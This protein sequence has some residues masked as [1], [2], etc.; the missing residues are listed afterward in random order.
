MSESTPK[1]VGENASSKRSKVPS[2]CLYLGREG[3]AHTYFLQPN[4]AHRCQATTP[5]SAM[6]LAHQQSYCFGACESCERYIAPLVPGRRARPKV[7]GTPAVGAVAEAVHSARNPKTFVDAPQDGAGPDEA[8]LET[9][10]SRGVSGAQNPNDAIAED[11]TRSWWQRFSFEEWT[12]LTVSAAMLG[13]IGYFM[14][15]AEPEGSRASNDLPPLIAGTATANALAVAEGRDKDDTPTKTPRPTRSSS[16]S[17]KADDPAK[18]DEPEATAIPTTRPLTPPAGGLIAALSPSERGVG[19]FREGIELPQYG[20]RNLEVGYFDGNHYLGGMLFSLNKIPDEA[21]VSYV[22]LELAGLSDFDSLDEGTWMVELLDPEIADEWADLTYDRLASAPATQMKTAW[23]LPASELAPRKINVLEFSNDALDLFNQRLAQGRVAFRISGPGFVP[24]PPRAVTKTA[25][26]ESDTDEELSDTDEATGE[27]GAESDSDTASEDS[28]ASTDEEDAGSSDS[29]EME[30][31][32]N[33]SEADATATSR[34]SSRATSQAR[35]PARNATSTPDSEDASA[36]GSSNESDRPSEENLFIWDTGYGSGFGTRPVLRVAF[37]PPTPTPN[38]NGNTRSGGGAPTPTP[39][40]LIVWISDPTPA[41]VAPT[42]T[43]F[44]LSVY[45]QLRGMV[46]F[47]SDRF[48]VKE[49]FAKPA[50][51]AKRP[52]GFT[53]PEQLMIYDPRTGRIGQVTQFWTYALAEERA[54][55]AQD[56]SVSV[57]G[58]GC[59]GRTITL[60]NGDEVLADAN[61]PGRECAQIM[62]F[63][64]YSPEPRELTHTGFTHYD[65]AV[66]PDGEWVVYT[67]QEGTSDG[68]EV[69]N[70]EIY[71]THRNGKDFV[72]LTF[73]DWEWDKHPSFSP[74]GQQI[75]FWSNRTGNKQLYIMNADGSGQVN[76]SNN[77][78]NDWDPIWVR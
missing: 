39:L 50:K 75:I 76:I 53:Q 34:A 9:D 51:G 46:L 14:F 56:V 67:S 68:V 1:S 74:D 8:S 16:G 35:R 4:A 72:R 29:D 49:G 42:A 36:S 71:K 69:N 5:D 10:R 3:D 54:R 48:E 52:A 12:V 73:N 32:P 18:Q 70:D 25:T 77:S 20:D 47:V 23:K 21:R 65:P 22:A 38:P 37:V 33:L 61:D 19:T 45:D 57:K 58:V 63:D 2:V 62:I 64:Q 28:E 66:S 44:P 6:D 59:G 41:P 60:E 78:Y 13:V 43:P 30:I 27:A 7:A 31:D 11:G 24:L 40:P 17:S 55:R 26:P 15:V